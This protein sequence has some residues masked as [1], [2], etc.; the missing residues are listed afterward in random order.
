MNEDFKQGDEIMIK[1][2]KNDLICNNWVYLVYDRKNG[3][4]EMPSYMQ[5]LKHFLGWN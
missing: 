4:K 2:S 5:R 1:A 3:E